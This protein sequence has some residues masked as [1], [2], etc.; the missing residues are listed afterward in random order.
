MGFSNSVRLGAD[1]CKAGQ[2][3]RLGGCIF[4]CAE[5]GTGCDFYSGR[6]ADMDKSDQ[7]KR[8][9]CR[10]QAKEHP[11]K[12]AAWIG[13]ISLFALLAGCGGGGGSA[14]T[15]PSARPIA[16][17][18]LRTFVSGDRIQYS[19]AGS[20]SAGG[21]TAHITGTAS[22]TI[23]TNASPV[24]PTG[25][26]RSVAVLAIAGT[27]PNG[28]S[29]T[30]NGSEYF[31]QTATGTK[32]TYGNSAAGWIATP[33]SGFVPTLVSPIITPNSWVITYTQQNGDTTTDQISA[34]GK[35]TITTGMGAFETFKY[36]SNSTTTL[37]AGGT[38]ISTT[39][40]YVV[41]AIGPVKM[42][43]NQTSTDAAG[44]VTTSQ[45]T[46]TAST[47]NIPF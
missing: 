28:A 33:T 27:L 12:T 44:T 41:P 16:S 17:N 10:H 13:A 4:H 25:A 24:D 6:I 45:L 3:F 11:M 23:T 5:N 38:R 26:T 39:V 34:I 32:N 30:S 19:L 29:V 20:I 35:T 40:T 18:T 14:A 31:S 43:I 9:I 15:P 22:Y 37:A 46:L 36:Q 7:E 2:L 47:T 42:T 1:I 8:T 21:V